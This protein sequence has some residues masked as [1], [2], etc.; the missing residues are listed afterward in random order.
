M[1]ELATGILVEMTV[2]MEDNYED[3]MKGMI[4]K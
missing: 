1:D 2:D 3:Y 4:T